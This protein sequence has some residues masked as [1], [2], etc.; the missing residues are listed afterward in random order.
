MGRRLPMRRIARHP[1][2]RSGT[3]RPV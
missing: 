3:N 2:L 1:P